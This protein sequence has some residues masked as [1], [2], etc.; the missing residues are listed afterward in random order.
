MHHRCRFI[1]IR[2]CP[3]EMLSHADL[4]AVLVRPDIGNDAIE[5]AGPEIP[6]AVIRDRNALVDAGRGGLEFI[7]F[8]RAEG[9]SG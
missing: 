7:S 9:R 4:S 8:E 3:A 6:A 1:D 2:Y 5:R